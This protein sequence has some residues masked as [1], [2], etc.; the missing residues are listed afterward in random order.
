MNLF[1]RIS[2]YRYDYPNRYS[3]VKFIDYMITDLNKSVAFEIPKE[4]EAVSNIIRGVFGYSRYEPTNPYTFHKRV[5]A[6]RNVHVNEA[7]FICD[8]NVCRYNC[9]KDMFECIRYSE[10]EKGNL[11]LVVVAE[12]W[13]IMKFYG[14]F[15]LVLPLL[16][17]GHILAQLRMDLENSG[18]TE[19]DI[20]YGAKDGD[21]YRRLGISS[22]SNLITLEINFKNR[23]S[24][25]SDTRIDGAYKRSM[26]YDE[27]VSAYD[28]SNQLLLHEA[29]F[30]VRKLICNQNKLTPFLAV[31]NRESA[32]NHI[33]IC[34]LEETVS[35]KL[36]V[37]YTMR[38]CEYMNHYMDDVDR[39]CV[40]VLY[41]TRTGQKMIQIDQGMMSEATKM[42]VNKSQLLHDT[43][44]MIDMESMPI[45]VYISYLYDE[46]LSEKENIYNAHI[47]S[48]EISHFFLLNGPQNGLFGRPMRN[49]EDSYVE[50]V[51]SAQ[52]N[53]R[54]MY[55]LIMGKANTKNCVHRLSGIKEVSNEME[56]NTPIHI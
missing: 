55:S 26:N 40:Y 17:V 19:V 41:T 4:A 34:S 36:V 50:K 13:R 20:L 32:H 2:R 23:V 39:Y 48:A 35:E 53:E 27:E 51:F 11:R 16:D 14:E 49:L 22:I 6:A 43:E 47:G 21:E 3:S 45:I 56:S 54:F 18:I 15:G 46:K 5:P 12:L 44:R 42:V 29:G 10:E 37:E 24:C 7:Y 31:Q 30:R 52:E 1:N 28:I 25:K 9:K 8:G 33:G 38:L